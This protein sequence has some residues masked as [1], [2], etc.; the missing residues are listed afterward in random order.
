MR[1]LILGGAGPR[2][3]PSSAARLPLGVPAIGLVVEAALGA[4]VPG[5]AKA[6]QVEQDVVAA[7]GL[8]TPVAPAPRRAAAFRRPLRAATRASAAGEGPLRHGLTPWPTFPESQVREASVEVSAAPW[9]RRAYLV[10]RMGPGALE[11]LTIQEVEGEA[12]AS[13]EAATLL[14]GAPV[15]RPIGLRLQA[16]VPALAEAGPATARRVAQ[17]PVVIDGLPLVTTVE[18]LMGDVRVGLDTLRPEAG[19]EATAGAVVL[20]TAT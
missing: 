18:L 3:L 19:T 9:L 12:F 13:E 7:G 5:L 11:L 20:A 4:V 17:T 14:R 1:P 15:R 16:S 6:V 2:R 10:P 8:H